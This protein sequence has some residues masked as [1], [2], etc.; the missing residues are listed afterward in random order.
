MLRGINLGPHRRVPMA[1]L[2]AALSEA[3]YEQVRTLLASGNVVL[4]SDAD[5][6]RLRE[7][8]D[9]LLS[10][11]FGFAIL[12]ISGAGLVLLLLG[13][14]AALAG[15][16]PGAI[17]LMHDGGGDRSETV[18]ALPLVISRL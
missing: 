16:Q 18:A 15:A 6:T 14:L 5:P 12:P 17:I 9:R 4:S 11:R 10:A 7:E 1:D 13:Y 3:G 8:C 2:R